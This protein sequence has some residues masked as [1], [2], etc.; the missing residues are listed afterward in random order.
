MSLLTERNVQYKIPNLEN[1]I[2]NYFQ[3][4]HEMKMI[5]N[6]HM[7]NMNDT[8]RRQREDGFYLF[9]VQKRNDAHGI[10]IYKETQPCGW[11]EF[12][13]FDPN[14]RKYANRGYNLSINYNKPHSFSYTMS[15]ANVWN[16][17]AGYCA[18]WCIIVIILWNSFDHWT[19]L[20]LFDNKMAKSSGIRKKFIEDIY[21]MIVRGKNFDTPMEIKDFIHHVRDRIEAALL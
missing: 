18:I 21:G 14:G 10:L 17:Q 1:G 11:V 5:C 2:A 4:V 13:L 20:H 8:R 7:E 19:T 9:S 12:H 16:D 3:N 6:R 15:P